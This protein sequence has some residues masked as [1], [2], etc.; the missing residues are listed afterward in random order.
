MMNTSQT[1][2]QS[3]LNRY[4]LTSAENY[5]RQ[6]AVQ[7]NVSASLS[8]I[9]LTGILGVGVAGFC[10]FL[11][12][13]A[14][15]PL[16]PM[17]IDSFHASKA[18]VSLTVS[19]AS[20]AVACSAPFIGVLSD[21]IGR[22]NL[23]IPATFL[24]VIPT[25]LAAAASSVLELVT[26]RFL[27]GLILPAIFAVTLAYVCEEWSEHGLGRALSVYVSSN[28]IGGFSGRLISGMVAASYGWR[29]AF[30]VLAVTEVIGALL[31]WLLLPAS[32]NFK[33]SAGKV[34]MFKTIKILLADRRLV[35]S[36][37]VGFNILFSLVATFTY[38]TF[39][40]SARPFLLDARALSLLF[41][42][43]LV[44]AVTTPY[45]GKFID[46]LGFR[47]TLVLAMAISAS[48]VLL[49]LIPNL[50]VI[51]F[52]LTTTCSS[53]FLCQSATQ[54]SLRKFAAQHTSA[55]AG[56][57]VCLYYLGG[58]LGGFLPSL[59]W[60]AGGWTACVA[61]IIC[62]HLIAMTCAF[63]FWRSAAPLACGQT[64]SV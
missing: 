50:Y 20:L 21:R 60:D 9:P 19:A 43:Y 30:I 33:A 7:A 52:G 36:F 2:A 47:E 28:V 58:C 46:S 29:T 42:V 17:L 62:C 5:N 27:Q 23:I 44:G 1:K 35:A 3:V 48:G 51:L 10:S 14:T 38:I 56:L 16:L 39:H 49:T 26:Y 57:Y 37:T 55:A 61:L 15:Q 22:K 41:A 63:K 32:K 59:A 64:R 31:I 53:L 18:E 4:R 11:N 24:L 6:D 40:L 45:A 12:L 13:Y 25:L 54:T 8:A 34:A